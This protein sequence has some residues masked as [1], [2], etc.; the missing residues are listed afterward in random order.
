M[1]RSLLRSLQLEEAE[2]FLRA[3][4]VELPKEMTHKKS[5]DKDKHK[6]KKSKKEKKERRTK[7]MG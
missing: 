5:K 4:G 3:A 7:D 1:S 2:A 6:R